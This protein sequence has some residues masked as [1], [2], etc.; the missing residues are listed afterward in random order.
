VEITLYWFGHR[1]TAAPIQFHK[2]LKSSLQL[3]ILVQFSRIVTLFDQ[4]HFLTWLQDDSLFRN[5]TEFILVDDASSQPMPAGLAEL[6]HARGI[7]LITLPRNAGRCIARNTGAQV[8]QG[9]YL[10]FIDGDDLPLTLSVDPGWATSS[11]DIVS[12]PFLVHGQGKSMRASFVRH[13]LLAIAGAP[14][15]YIDP[16]PAAVL[17]RRQYFIDVGGFDPRYELAEDLELLLRTRKA[18]H[19][20]ARQPKQSYNEQPRTTAAEIACS[21][22]RLRIYQKLHPKQT[23]P[24]SLMASEVRLVHLQATWYLLQRGHQRH[25]FRA[26]LSLLWNLGKARF[27]FIPHID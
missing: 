25:L 13:P 19:A 26:A 16:R 23:A 17:W 4:W 18:R 10:D 15:G 27:G 12:F 20:F 22:Q 6:I 14:E 3:I 8:A 21:V 2:H 5:D 7:K 11:P 9:T 1:T 24:E